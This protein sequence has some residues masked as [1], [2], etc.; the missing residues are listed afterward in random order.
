MT[1]L[2]PV[3]ACKQASPKEEEEGRKEGGR[4]AV[5]AMDRAAKE[6]AKPVTNTTTADALQL[7]MILVFVVQ[8]LHCL[9]T[10]AAPP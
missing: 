7:N 8:R 3:D 5:E 4:R 10:N 6:L 9:Y 1:T 2:Q